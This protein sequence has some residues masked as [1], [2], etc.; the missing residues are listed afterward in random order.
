V[1]Q[2]E[3][4]DVTGI[5]RAARAEDGREVLQ[6]SFA[7]SADFSNTYRSVMLLSDASDGALTLSRRTP[8]INSNL[9]FK[10]NGLLESL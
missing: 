2:L 9:F 10:S 4:A 5:K 3:T 6:R 1:T 7:P 8:F